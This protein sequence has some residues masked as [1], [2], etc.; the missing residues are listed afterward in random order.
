VKIVNGERSEGYSRLSLF[1]ARFL[2]SIPFSQKS[3]Y[4]NSSPYT[5]LK[6]QN[7]HPGLISMT[8]EPMGFSAPTE[9]VSKL[10]LLLAVARA[11]GAVLSAKDIDELT[12]LLPDE[13]ELRSMWNRIPSLN[14]RYS[15][16]SGLLVEK[17]P[18]N[19]LPCHETL[20]DSRQ[21]R[22]RAERYIEYAREFSYLSGKRWIRVF[23]VAGSTSYKTTSENDDIDIF[24]VTEKHSLW[25]YLTKALLLARVFKLARPGSPRFCF[26]CAIGEDYARILFSSPNDALFARDALTAQVLRGSLFYDGLLQRG[27]WLAAYF[28]K[29]YMLRKDQRTETLEENRIARPSPAQKALNHFLFLTVGNYIRLKSMLLNRKLRKTGR[30]D[31]RFRI[32]SGRDHCIFESQSYQQ[33]RL[34][35]RE[36]RPYSVKHQPSNWRVHST[37]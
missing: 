9:E 26:S 37:Q 32:I 29:L 10:E 8:E 17:L 19:D 2:R 27:Q 28:P 4:D 6:I 25:I 34:M 22:A 18:I 36:I 23:S 31:S 13:S 11:K 12:S 24:C 30:L 20:S 21:R 16:Q 1:S 14:S 3:Y 35:Y 15:L 7:G 5:L 33:L